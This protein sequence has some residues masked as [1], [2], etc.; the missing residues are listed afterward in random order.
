LWASKARLLALAVLD[1]EPVP[2]LGVDLQPYLRETGR[3]DGLTENDGIAYQGSI[4]LGDGFTVEPDEA[5]EMIEA[6]PKNADVLVPFVVGADLNRRPDMSASRWVINFRD[7]PLDR[8]EE[9]GTL[10]DRVRRL[11]KPDRDRTAH[12]RNHPWWQFLRGR[13]ELYAAIR[14][15]TN[16]LAISRHGDVLIPVRVPTGVVFSDATVVFA[17]DGFGDLGI[18]SSSA[19]QLWLLRYASTMETRIRYT[20]SD[21][22][23]TFPR[24][25]ATARLE[26]LGEELDEQRRQLMRD[27]AVGLTKLYNLVHKP[28]VLDSAIVRLRE[29][30]E[31]IDHATLSAYGWSDLDPQIGHWPTKIGTRWTVSPQARFELLDRLLVENHRRAAAQGS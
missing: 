3:P 12:G 9:Y 19:H 25:T 11:V 20:P 16:V 14:E 18:M 4:I 22:F 28:E 2:R 21:V 24:P 1:G 8:A 17:L 23:M 31:Q 26:A 5:R 13:R 27:R 6:A 30:H 29:L 10:L 15:K 7:W